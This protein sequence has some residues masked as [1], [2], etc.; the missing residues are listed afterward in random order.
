MRSREQV[1]FQLLYSFNDG[2]EWIVDIELEDNIQDKLMNYIDRV[3]QNPDTGPLMR[4]YLKA[5][6]FHHF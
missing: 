2:Y 6:T 5:E 3:N 4:K 1:I